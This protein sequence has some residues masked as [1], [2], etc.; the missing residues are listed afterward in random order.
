MQFE[1]DPCLICELEDQKV[2]RL[3]DTSENVSW[4]VRCDRCGH[5]GVASQDVATALSRM[6][7][8]NRPKF[9]G[10]IRG[11]N[12]S[13]RNPNIDMTIFD[14]RI[15]SNMPTSNQRALFYIAEALYDV[16]GVGEHFRFLHE[17]YVGATYSES[18][19]GLQEL[20]RYLN[21][22]GFF[23]QMTMGGENSQAVVTVKGEEAALDIDK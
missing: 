10:W 5:Y 15:E 21:D 20:L 7:R 23:A 1:N 19:E 17:R 22:C 16:G 8:H 14:E 13:E 12:R 3:G 2:G 18:S 6:R 11:E 4:E 9:S